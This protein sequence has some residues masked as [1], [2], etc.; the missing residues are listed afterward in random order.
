MGSDAPGLEHKGQQQQ[1]DM[2]PFVHSGQKLGAPGFSGDE[3][4]DVAE[5]DPK[6]A[7]P[8]NA[9]MELEIGA[10]MI[11]PASAAAPAPRD[12]VRDER[13]LSKETEASSTPGAGISNAS[14]T[15]F[16]LQEAASSS[17]LGQ[18]SSMAVMYFCKEL[19]ELQ[20][21]QQKDGG[22]LTR[23]RRE[24]TFRTGAQYDGQWLGNQ[25]DGFG[26]M[27]WA[28][29]A[30][31][32]GEWSS[33]QAKGKGRFSTPEGNTYIGEWRNNRCHGC[34]CFAHREG[35]MYQ[36][37]FHDDV[38][39]GHGV[40]SWVDNS[41]FA[42]VYVHGKKC[43][44]GVYDWPDKSKYSGQWANNCIEGYGRFQNQ[45][46]EFSGLWR[47]SSMHGAGRHSWSDGKLFEGQYT[48]DQ[49]DGFGI[50]TWPDGRKYEGFWGRGRQHGLGRLSNVNGE[51]RLGEWRNGER[52][53]WVTDSASEEKGKPSKKDASTQPSLSLGS[54]SV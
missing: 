44:P 50:F 28:D 37:E 54:G 14:P 45:E 18:S 15:T 47:V 7:R 41:K 9:K 36:G 43:G 35:T 40:E 17:D 33:N 38:Q 29:G 53:N 13:M 10:S 8:K 31:Y 4:L 49:K 11:S 12:V 27:T 6:T 42:G 5:I 32:E 3:N 23:Q 48:R 20:E 22:P 26:T 51:V 46:K 25:R 21:L 16:G 39:H 19:P 34:G 2:Q 30:K 24:H 1:S 52:I